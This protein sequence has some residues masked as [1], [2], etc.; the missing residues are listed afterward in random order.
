MIEPKCV[1]WKRLGADQ[2]HKKIKGF[3]L[4]QEL[5]FWHKQTEE[6]KLSQQ[7]ARKLSSGKTV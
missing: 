2:V 6:L 7:Q 3:T 4:A 1:L 5:E